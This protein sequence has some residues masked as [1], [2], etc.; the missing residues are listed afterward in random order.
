MFIR[1]TRDQIEQPIACDGLR[2]GLAK[3]A[4]IQARVS[5]ASQFAGDASFRKRFNG[6]YRV[7]RNDAWQMSFYDVMDC[8]R[9]DPLSFLA[10]LNAL[11]VRTGQCEASFASKLHATLNPDWP[12]IDAMVLGR[13]G[14]RLPWAGVSNRFVHIDR[15]YSDLA[16]CFRGYLASSDGR[17]LVKA[18]RATHGEQR[19]TETKMLYLVLWQCR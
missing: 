17:Y 19:V 11:F 4:A 5:I 9:R 10:T 2:V 1:L 3:Y 15:L 12:V 16:E 8:A 6:F 13:V 14:A 18:F 7:R